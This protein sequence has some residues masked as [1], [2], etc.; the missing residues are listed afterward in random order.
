M[1]NLLAGFVACLLGG[2]PVPAWS[3][4]PVQLSFETGFHLGRTVIRGSEQP[5]LHGPTRS[6][7]FTVDTGTQYD[8]WLDAKNAAASQRSL[9]L[10]IYSDSDEGVKDKIELNVV[11]HNQPERLTIGD[12]G[13]RYLSF[14]FMLDPEYEAPRAWVI[15]VQAW[16]CCGKPPPFAI[17]VAPKAHVRSEVE[18]RFLV[19]DDVTERTNPRS[20]GREIHRMTVPRG[21]WNNMAIFMQPSVGDDGRDGRLI[22]WYN[23]AQTLDYRG[24][25]GYRSEQLTR[26]GRAMSPHMAVKIGIYRKRQ[27]TMQTIFVDNVRFGSTYESVMN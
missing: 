1:R 25:W 17:R 21:R 2:F 11:K 27:A 23:R 20:E 9:A 18:F 12:N 6:F 16:Q 10:K 26:Q 13:A 19:R 8:V 5:R 4:E 14:D 22:V 3:F 7:D 24:S 15:H